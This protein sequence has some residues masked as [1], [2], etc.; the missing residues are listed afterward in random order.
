M[1][2]T[3][4]LTVPSFALLSEL[5]DPFVGLAIREEQDLA[6]VGAAWA[7]VAAIMLG[8]TYGVWRRRRRISSARP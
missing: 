8:S 6:Y 3:L 1:L 5:A 2:A 4:L 7:S